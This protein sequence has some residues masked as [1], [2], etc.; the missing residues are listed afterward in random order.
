M[1]EK[2]QIKNILKTAI[3]LIIVLIA[4]LI[5]VILF[6]N[7]VI[8]HKKSSNNLSNIQKSSSNEAEYGKLIN[9]VR[10]GIDFDWNGGSYEELNLKNKVFTSYS[11]LEQYFTNLESKINKEIG[12][13][14]SY[15]NDNSV[16]KHF[17]NFD[18]NNNSLVLWVKNNNIKDDM[19]VKGVYIDDNDNLTVLIEQIL[20]SNSAYNK[21]NKNAN[22]HLDFISLN[23]NSGKPVKFVYKKTNKTFH[24]DATYK[25]IIYLYPTEDTEV[26]VKLL[27]CENL[28]CS[29]PKYKDEWKV[30]AQSDGTLKDLVTNRK[31]YSLYY[32]S[33]NDIKFNIENEGFVVKGEDTI[34]FLEEKLAVLG[35]TEREAEEFI[36]YWLP[37]LEANK[38]NYIRFA[39]T[40][41]INENMP[42]EINPNPDKI[43]RVLM[44]F[45]GLENPI[46]VQEQQLKTPDRTGFVAIEWGGTEIQ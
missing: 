8:G 46:D 29:Y 12:F 16:Y 4:I 26:S 35:L 24:S 38:Y 34:Q 17:E 13:D 22:V 3:I 44:T 41:E 20:D 30:L 42:L 6:S 27:K 25:P 39:T 18:F 23:G 1:E 45:K 33:K 19:Y 15:N 14:Y 11:E 28:T 36:V 9:Y 40:D 2:K 5:S 31:L 7:Y 21:N 37:K 43:I 10:S 32:E